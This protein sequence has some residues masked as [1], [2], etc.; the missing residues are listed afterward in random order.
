MLQQQ[1]SRL[2][3][4]IEVSFNE[5]LFGRY[6]SAWAEHLYSAWLQSWQ[7]DDPGIL[8]GA[9]ENISQRMIRREL[10]IQVLADAA[11]VL[12]QFS[13]SVTTDDEILT[14]L[15]DRQLQVRLAID[16]LV[17]RGDLKYRFNVFM[18][19]LRVRLFGERL[20]SQ[21]DL[22]GAF[23][24]MSQSLPNLGISRFYLVLYDQ[25]RATGKFHELP[26]WSYLAFAH[27]ENGSVTPDFREQRFLT[28]DLL[29]G[30]L[31]F[32][33]QFTKILFFP[34]YSNRQQFGYLV[35]DIDADDSRYHYDLIRDHVS[36][37]LESLLP[38]L[39][40]IANRDQLET[41]VTNKAYELALANEQLK[42]Y[43]AELERRNWE[44]QQF[45]HVAQNEL[46]EPLHNIRRLGDRLRG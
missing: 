19:D 8:L 44:L 43:T 13:R 40:L 2:L 33:G 20:L 10:N 26:Q 35:I 29:P 32:K 25:Q 39:E 18:R 17:Q 1:K 16:T 22:H 34:L 36:L 42:A 4:E 24:E 7:A 45:A 15:D 30:Y 11:H 9:L 37:T 46:L 28:A 41:E 38:K 12:F 3:A 31:Q 14:R 5:N 6:N 21:K 23:E 27:D